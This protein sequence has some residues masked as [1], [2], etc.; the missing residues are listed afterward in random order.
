MRPDDQERATDALAPTGKEDETYRKPN[1]G[2]ES[3]MPGGSSVR[4]LLKISLQGSNT[5]K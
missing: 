1:K 3:K 5:V 2:K 4:S